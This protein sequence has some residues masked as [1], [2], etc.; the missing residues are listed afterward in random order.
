LKPSSRR[1]LIVVLSDFLDA[2]QLPIGVWRRVARRHEVIALRFVEPREE[3]LPAV[4]LVDL[5]DAELGT[6][7]LVDT[8]SQRV[9][10]AYAAAAVERRKRFQE[11]G[12]AAGIAGYELSTTSDPIGPLTRIFT[13]RSHRRGAP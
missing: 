11:W 9:R 4:G 10:K 12:R 2:E 7:R 1:A 13:G 3:T 6:R 8:S 5:A